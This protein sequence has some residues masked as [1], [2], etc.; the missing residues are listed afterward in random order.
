MNRFDANLRTALREIGCTLYE[1]GG[2]H[3]TL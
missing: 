1:P 2:S 3:G